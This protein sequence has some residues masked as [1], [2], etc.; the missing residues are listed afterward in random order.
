MDK[1]SKEEYKH[2][3]ARNSYLTVD[4]LYSRWSGKVKKSTLN[5]WRYLKKGP[6]FLKVGGKILYREEDV[7]VFELSHYFEAQEKNLQIEIM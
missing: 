2:L 4:D 1:I 5:Q 3:L 7:R 6:K